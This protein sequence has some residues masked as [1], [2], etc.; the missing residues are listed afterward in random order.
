MYLQHFK[1]NEMPFSLTPD[2][3]FFMGRAGYRDALNV[4]LV[5]LRS[6][7]GIA[8]QRGEAARLA[9][10]RGAGRRAACSSSVSAPASIPYKR[11]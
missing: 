10:T 8:L 1:L 4:L 7:E 9:R 5:A 6:G 11:S 3:A 2:T